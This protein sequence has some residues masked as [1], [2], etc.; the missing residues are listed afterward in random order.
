MTLHWGLFAPATLLLLF[1][2]DRLLSSLVELRSFD[3]F[4][5]LDNSPRHRP[6]WWVPVLWLDP[7]RSFAGTWLLIRA[8]DLDVR[9]WSQLSKGGYGLLLAIVGASLVSQVFTRRGGDRVLLAPVGFVA[10]IILALTSWPLASLALAAAGVG[11]FAFRQF[12]AFFAC[13]ALSLPL[14]GVAL[15]AEL[16]WLAPAAGVLAAPFVAAWLSG[17]TLELPVRTQTLA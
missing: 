2:A 4:N 12:H 1:P 16:F 3:C 8:L 11:L 15:G 13:G 6:W 9:F 10:G 5:S 7:V 14:L 17:S